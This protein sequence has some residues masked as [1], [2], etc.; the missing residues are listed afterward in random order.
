MTLTTHRLLWSQNQKSVS[1]SDI[2][3]IVYRKPFLGS[4]SIVLETAGGQNIERLP[5][6]SNGEV[7]GNQLMSLIHWARQR[8]QQKPATTPAQARIE[9][10]RQ[11]AEL[12]AQGVLSEEEFQVEKARVL[13]QR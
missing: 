4:G 5:A 1:L 13:A 2:R 6:G 7:I 11:L 10:L 3:D 12:K 8:A 9:Q